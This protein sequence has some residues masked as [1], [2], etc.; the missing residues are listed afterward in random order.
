ML[1]VLVERAW[2]F[3]DLLVLLIIVVL[4]SRLVNS[5]DDMVWS[6]VATLT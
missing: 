4:G 2:A 6:A 5:G 3:K 1:G